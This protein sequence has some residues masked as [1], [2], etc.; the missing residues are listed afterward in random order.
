MKKML[1]NNEKMKVKKGAVIAVIMACLI[2]FTTFITF[3][4]TSPNT[5]KREVKR[6]EF[7]ALQNDV[8]SLQA[9]INTSSASLASLKNEVKALTEK[10]TDELSA[11]ET[12]HSNDIATINAKISAQEAEISKINEEIESLDTLCVEL[13]A[14]WGDTQIVPLMRELASDIAN[15]ENDLAILSKNFETFKSETETM[16]SDHAKRIE[17]LE[18]INARAGYGWDYTSGYTNVDFSVTN[19]GVTYSGYT[20]AVKYVSKTNNAAS[21]VVA[22]IY[23]TNAETVT[24]TDVKLTLATIGYEWRS[25]YLPITFALPPAYRPFAN[26]CPYVEIENYSWILDTTTNI[27]KFN[28][29]GM[30]THSLAS[31]RDDGVNYFHYVQ[32]IAVE[33]DTYNTGN[34]T[35]Y[36]KHIQLRLYNGVFA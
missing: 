25:G 30:F 23:V 34:L 9:R 13:I 21:M 15:V 18:A 6:I 28:G 1:N 32:G 3:L 5:F 17:Q 35:I 12:L 16:L 2:A 33:L 20:S 27:G 36:G 11:V 31:T 24:P 26:S 7:T 22:D 10:H 29:D 8:S 14:Y 19:Q 4:N